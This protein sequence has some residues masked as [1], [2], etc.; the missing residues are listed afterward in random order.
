MPTPSYL[1]TGQPTADNGGGLFGRFGSFFGGSTPA[2]TGDGQP[3]SSG[4]MLRVSTPAYTP[5]PTVRPS[6]DVEASELDAQAESCS[7]IDPEALAAGQIAI[8]IPRQG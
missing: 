1:G 6:Q 3:S 8:V 2:Y 7:M 5:A 4:S